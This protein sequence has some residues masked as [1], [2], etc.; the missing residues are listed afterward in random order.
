MSFPYETLPASK[1]FFSRPDDFDIYISNML[2]A[3]TFLGL[4]LCRIDKNKRASIIHNILDEDVRFLYA[5]NSLKVYAYIRLWKFALAGMGHLIVSSPYMKEYY[6]QLLNRSIKIDVIPYG[7]GCK[8]HF[9]PNPSGATSGLFHIIGCG[10]LIERKNF[11]LLI[12]AL[13]YLP[14]CRITIIGDGPQRDLLKKTAIDLCVEE[15]V[16]FLGNIDNISTQLISADCYAMSSFSE[17]FGLAMLEA[18]SMGIPT[19]C[20]DLKIYQGILPNDIFP[21][22]DP[23]SVTGIVDA[24]NTIKSNPKLYATGSKFIYNETFKLEKMVHSYMQ[25]VS[26]YY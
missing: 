16:A 20:S 2:L 17:G 4:F 5:G 24:I 22:F 7:V 14:D 10:N 8:Q 6:H 1:L 21:R 23:N 11:S 26:T 19:I 15:R 9:L 3:D 25:T 13:P 18:I 12:R